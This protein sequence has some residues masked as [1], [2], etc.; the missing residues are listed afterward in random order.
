M[1][2][3]DSAVG[4]VSNLT[5][6]I[7]NLS[8]AAAESGTVILNES[9]SARSERESESARPVTPSGGKQGKLKWKS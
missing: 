7:G 5:G 2:V 3:R 4:Q 8:Y 9:R 1:A 6:Q